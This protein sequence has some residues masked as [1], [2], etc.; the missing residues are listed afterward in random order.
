M[1]VLNRIQELIDG[2]V[3][4]RVRVTEEAARLPRATEGDTVHTAERCKATRFGW[5]GQDLHAEKDPLRSHLRCK[6]GAEPLRRTAVRTLCRDLILTVVLAARVKFGEC[7]S[8][9]FLQRTVAASFPR[10]A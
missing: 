5:A 8:S 4:H 9:P 1:D 10:S 3:A 6:H 7:Q 2:I